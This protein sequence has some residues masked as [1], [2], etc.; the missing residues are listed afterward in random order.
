M[1]TDYTISLI[2]KAD[3]A[4]LL[5]KYHYLKDISKGFK[6]GYN[7]G[8]FKHDE[9]VGVCIFTGFPVPELV[10]GA[11][12]LD[13][14][15]QDGFFELSRLVL[16]PDIQKD[17]HNLASWFVSRAIKSLRRAVPVRA[18][19]S[20]ADSSFHDGIVYRAS[21]FTYYGLTDVKKDFWIKTDDGYV[22]HSR[23]KIKGLDGEWRER[24]RKH[25]YMFVYDKSLNVLWKTH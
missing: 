18:I 19:L 16:H 17:E 20:Y 25:R 10:V 8:L 6:S 3:A 23:G 1:K 9:L 22:K 2:S 15:D 24:T 21:N 4:K 14:K 7:Y 11:F 12:G 5:L 13:R